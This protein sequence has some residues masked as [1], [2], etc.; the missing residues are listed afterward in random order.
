MTREPRYR[1]P[2]CLDDGLVIVF[3]QQT[4]NALRERI[5]PRTWYTKGTRCTCD[6]GTAKYSKVEPFDELRMCR[7]DY[8]PSEADR[9]SLREFVSQEILNSGTPWEPPAHG[10][11]WEPTE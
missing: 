5:E 8:H 3:H 9:E 2:T 4:I 6:A 10:D 7:S 11:A 1:C